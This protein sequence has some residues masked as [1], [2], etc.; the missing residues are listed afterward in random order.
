M[1][2]IVSVLDRIDRKLGGVLRVDAGE[3]PPSRPP[4]PGTS[5]TSTGFLFGW[6]TNLSQLFFVEVSWRAVIAVYG[7]SFWFEVVHAV[8][9]VV[10]AMV[11]AHEVLWVLRRYKRRFDVEYLDQGEPGGAPPVPD[12]V[13]P[14]RS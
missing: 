5:Q 10:V 11:F 1:N 14:A 8:T 2:Q 12:G 7:I 3:P 6:I 4:S 9:N 13:P